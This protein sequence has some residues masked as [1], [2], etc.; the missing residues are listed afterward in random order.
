MLLAGCLAG[1]APARAG[2]VESVLGTSPDHVRSVLISG[3]DE[4]PERAVRYALLVD[5]RDDFDAR[6]VDADVRRLEGLGVFEQVRAR[7]ERTPNGVDVRYLVRERRPRPPVRIG[8]VR[9][10]GNEDTD[11]RVVTQEMRLGPGDRVNWETLAIS[12]REVDELRLFSRIAYRFEPMEE[13]PGGQGIRTVALIVDVR[14][15]FTRFG[16]V[17]PTYSSDNPDFGGVGPVGGYIDRNF[18]GTGNQLYAGG[19]WAETRILGV[20]AAIPHAFGT[21]GHLALFGAYGDQT[22][23]VYER[24]ARPFNGEYRAELAAAGGYWRQP[25]DRDEHWNIGAGF[26]YVRSHF[27]EEDGPVPA[28]DG[29]GPVLV[30][31]ISLDRRD[32]PAE[33]VSGY[34]AGVR[35]DLGYQYSEAPESDRGFFRLN[36]EVQKFFPLGRR[37]T[38][39]V[40]ARGGIA[41]PDVPFLA[42][43]TLGG[44]SSMRGYPSG[45]IRGDTYVWGVTEYRFPMLELR[46]DRALTGVLFAEA[47]DAWDRGSDD[48]PFQ[49]R[50]SGGLGLRV[51]AGAFI[52]RA[53]YAVSPVDSGFYVFLGH[54]F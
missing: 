47:G 29:E 23:E 39:A 3:L 49:W 2:L 50:K 27:E 37:H 54:Y 32:D 9:V 18:L 33:P 52:V 13:A 45:S 30:G 31:G 35:L 8:A 21:S 41:S 34:Y 53:D 40:M 43:Y 20:G 1:L 17:W 25:L 22:Q 38:V 26:G 6:A 12:M 42:E 36:P 19:I 46:Q 4:L 15:G 48:A 16:F 44:Q 14:E 10:A 28:A 24:D 51:I 7:I 11:A 5:P